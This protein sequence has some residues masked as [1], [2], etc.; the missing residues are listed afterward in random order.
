[1][2]KKFIA[3][4]TLKDAQEGQEEGSLEAVISTFDILDHD[5]E[6]VAASAFKDGQE[7]PMVWSHDWSKLIG[8]GTIRVDTDRAVFN[9]QMFM[10]TVAGVEAFRLM[11]GLG[12]LQQFSWGFRVTNAETVEHQGQQVRRI[13]ETEAYEVSAVLVGSNPQTGILAIKGHGLTF[14][15]HSESV[16]VAVSEWIERTRSGTETRLKEGRA[17]SAARRS[18]MASVSEALRSGADEIDAL[19]K[20]T[21][22]PEKAVDETG[23]Q[24][25]RV[26]VL[27]LRSEFDRGN[28]RRTRELGVSA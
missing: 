16:Q 2:F 13:L 28:A 22:P 10:D 11:R 19:L 6:M 7:L 15:D 9:G 25:Q 4:V 5:G 20:E 23:A 12:S 21:A 1:M 18:R 27:R 14:D 3:P 24:A 17:I 26:A 8:K